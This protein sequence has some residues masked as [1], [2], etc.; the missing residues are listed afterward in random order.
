MSR[1]RSLGG[2]DEAADA[3]DADAAAD[4]QQHARQAPLA[5]REPHPRPG[6]ARQAKRIPLRSSPQ[7]AKQTA[8]GS[9]ET[10]IGAFLLGQAE[11]RRSASAVMVRARSIP[12]KCRREVVGLPGHF[13]ARASLANGAI[14]PRCCQNQSPAVVFGVALQRPRRESRCSRLNPPGR[15]GVLFLS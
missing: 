7:P 12:V 8:N 15:E 6:I 3:E 10:F 13:R 2:T 14:H 4:P 11:P 5:P 9:S 1:R